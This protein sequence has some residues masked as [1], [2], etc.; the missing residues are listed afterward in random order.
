MKLQWTE[1]GWDDYLYWQE[2]DS[3]F[4]QKINVLIKDTRRSPFQGLGKPEPLRNEM[5]G[6]WSRRID[7]EH[8]LI[9]RVTGKGEAQ[10]L[11]IA[12]CRFHYGR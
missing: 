8:R 12:A 6:W 5:A 7:R 10:A 3:D 1:Q 2:H 11:E 4:I 9:Y